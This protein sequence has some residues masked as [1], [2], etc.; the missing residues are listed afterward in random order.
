MQADRALR[1]MPAITECRAGPALDAGPRFIGKTARRQAP[2]PSRGHKPVETAAALHLAASL[3]LGRLLKRE[4]V[5]VLRN[6]ASLVVFARLPP[7]LLGPQQLDDR[8]ERDFSHC[9]LSEL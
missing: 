1:M 3:R 6:W 9:E 4:I 2:R 5:Q 7:D 8:F